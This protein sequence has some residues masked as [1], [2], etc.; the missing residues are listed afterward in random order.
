MIKLI[1][2]GA[3]L[4]VSHDGRQTPF[5]DWANPLV[6]DLGV[7][8]EISATRNAPGNYQISLSSES[9]QG[10]ENYNRIKALVVLT[11][12]LTEGGYPRTT[13]DGLQVLNL[14]TSG[15]AREGGGRSARASLF[16]NL[17]NLQKTQA[18]SGH[19]VTESAGETRFTNA[20]SE[21][22][23]RDGDIDAFLTKYAALS[24]AAQTSILEG[25]LKK[26]GTSVASETSHVEVV[27]EEEVVGM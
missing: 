18:I 10:V 22:V 9:W 26:M 27:D 6:A 8:F 7:K 23:A 19:T 2:R 11:D 17:A 4:F 25:Q 21:F 12:A 20:M 5:L 15:P 24:Q 3:A 1:P 14:S 13:E 16:I